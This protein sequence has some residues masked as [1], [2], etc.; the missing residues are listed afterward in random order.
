MDKLLDLAAIA[1][2]NKNDSETTPISTKDS[3]NVCLSGTE[4][5]SPWLRLLASGQTDP[6]SRRGEPEENENQRSERRQYAMMSGAHVRDKRPRPQQRDPRPPFLRYTPFETLDDLITS[7]SDDGKGENADVNPFF[8]RHQTN[9]QTF[10]D[11]DENTSTGTTSS[12]EGADDEHATWYCNG[13]LPSSNPKNQAKRKKRKLRGA[14]EYTPRLSRS[15]SMSPSSPREV[16]PSSRD[17]QIRGDTHDGSDAISALDKDDVLDPKSIAKRSV[18]VTSSRSP[19]CFIRWL[20]D[21]SDEKNNLNTND[22]VSKKRKKKEAVEDQ[23][24]AEQLQR[25]EADAAAKKAVKRK[26]RMELEERGEMLNS[27]DGKAVLAVQE[28]VALVQ[29][30]KDKYING[31]PALQQLCVETVAMDDMVFM[32]KNMLDKQEDFTQRRVSGHIGKLHD[33]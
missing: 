30:V 29:S 32:A 18:G 7:E 31:N 20:L 26:K 2:A 10:Q 27:S 11:D 3:N 15:W 24:L 6:P 1:T 28:I 19:T 12:D 14:A 5:E 25:I 23:A 8:L 9:A 17:R 13:L 4:A 16:Q 22:R 33:W 21:S